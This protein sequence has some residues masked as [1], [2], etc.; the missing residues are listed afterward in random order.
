MFPITSGGSSRHISSAS[1]RLALGA[2]ALATLG[3][4]AC[5]AP[6]SSSAPSAS[7]AGASA[8]ASGQSV[9]T[10]APKGPVTLNFYVETGFP[11][12]EKLAD[13][14]QK[15]YPNIKIKLRE[16]QFQVLTQNAPRVMAG[17]DAPDLIRLPTI[18]N[19]VKDGLLADLDPYAHAYG[20]D[21]YP[22]GLMNQMRVSSQGIRGSGPLYALGIG[23]DITGVFYNKALAAR[24]GMTQPP[25]TIA[26]LESDLAKAKAAGIQP[27]EQFNDIGGV[28]F[29][30]QAL[31]NQ[32]E[33]PAKIADWVFDKPGATID[34]PATV[35]AADRIA[36]WGK[37][38][39]FTKDANAL[40]Y[41]DMMANF[42]KGKALFMFNG[43]WESQNLTKA[44]GK[45]V[46]FFLSP[47]A[48]AGNK[49]VAMSAPGTY[50][51][52]AKAKHIAATAF[53]LNWVHTN[54]KARQIIV[55]VNGSS[56]GGPA[57]LPQPSVAD[58]SV[59]A[60]TLEATKE[61][62]EN[63]VAVDFTANATAGIYANTIKP[64]LQQLITGRETGAGV[65]KKM[66]ADW[67]K[68]LAQ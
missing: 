17:N 48:A 2:V 51:I 29:P 18:V 24:I 56:P 10:T 62:A 61:L 44:L 43:D 38:G 30:F 23:Y 26:E 66:Q 47:P 37:A 31:I 49:L 57:D 14:F 7:A 35:K 1:R 40:S 21:K 50:A 67:A 63:G 53:F 11:L 45:D 58:D 28:N 13:E 8:D 68:E 55:D 3:V 64:E 65:A 6:G 41:T 15:E 54:P 36:A 52:P 25:K 4:A 59:V 46:G 12:P 5:G 39:Y 20:W 9:A 27:I 16:D 60:A 32:Y 42:E 19:S 34:T 33:D 22:A